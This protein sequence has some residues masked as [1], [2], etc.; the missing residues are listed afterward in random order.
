MG[1][2][3][4]QS[5]DRSIDFSINQQQVGLEMTFAI[6]TA[7]ITDQIEKIGQ[8]LGNAAH[9]SIPSRRAEIISG[10]GSCPLSSLGK[11]LVIS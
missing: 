1:T 6:A 9:V 11:V 7:H 10:G 4:G 2:K 5:Q 8:S 3:T